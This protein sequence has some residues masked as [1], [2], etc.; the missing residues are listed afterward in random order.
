MKNYVVNEIFYSLQGEGARAGTAN[1]FIRFAGCNLQ[2][3]M[4]REGFNCDTDF[5]SGKRMTANE[6]VTEAKSLGGRCRWVIFTGGE[7]MLQLDKELLQAFHAE[8]FCCA[9]ETNGTRQIPFHLDWITCSPKPFSDI[10]LAFA[11]EVKCVLSAGMSPNDFGINTSRR[12]VSPAFR[13]PAVDDI[14][15]WKVST[16]DLDATSLDWCVEWCK[17]NPEWQLSVQQHKLWGVR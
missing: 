7:P 12:L 5:R 2:C 10:K 1:V 15:A 9:I 6:I 4:E 16:G 3:S 11:D 14:D 8:G 13:A 17:N